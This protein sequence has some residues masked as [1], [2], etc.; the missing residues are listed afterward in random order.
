MDEDIEGACMAA[1][2]AVFPE[3]CPDY[4][5]RIAGE[6]DYDAESVISFIADEAENGRSYP[7]RQKSIL[8]RKRDSDNDNDEDVARKF[9]SEDRHQEQKPAAYTM[10]SCVPPLATFSLTNPS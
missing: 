6:C 9:D 8:K 2:L 7:K 10:L 4:L 3:I 5:T 1:V